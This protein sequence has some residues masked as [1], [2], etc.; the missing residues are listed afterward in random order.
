MGHQAHPQA[1]R[2]RSRHPL[3]VSFAMALIISKPLRTL[4]GESSRNKLRERQPAPAVEFG[5]MDGL[6][7]APDFAFGRAVHKISGDNW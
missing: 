7:E 1:C 4:Q 2:Q 5:K 6:R 3:V